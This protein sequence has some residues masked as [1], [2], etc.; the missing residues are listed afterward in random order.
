MGMI[1]V[2]RLSKTY[3]NFDSPWRRMYEWMF[4]IAH[5]ELK[6]TRL[7]LDDINFK[8]GSGEAVGIIGINGAGKSTLLKM[9]AGTAYPT[10]G[11]VKIT[12]SLASILELGLGFRPELTGRQNATTALQLLGNDFKRTQQL[13]DDVEEFAELGDYFELPLRVYSSGMQ[14]RL[15][16]S[17]VTA[18]RPDILV[19]DEALSVGDAYFQH[20]SF[21]RIRGF[22]ALGTTLLMV[23]HDKQAILAVCDRVILLND[24][25]IEREGD[26]E[27]VLDYYNAKLSHRRDTKISQEL[28][29]AGRVR[30][31]SGTKEVFIE[32]ISLLD[33]SDHEASMLKT[34]E[35][36]SIIVKYGSN[37]VVHDLVVGV[38]IKD[39]FGQAVFGTNSYHLKV[40]LP[41]MDPGN[42]GRVKFAFPVNLGEG[43]YSVSIALHKG[44]THVAH[45]FDWLDHAL[46]FE[47][48]NTSYT[49]FIGSTFLP[50]SLDVICE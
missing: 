6:S 13:L 31:S 17:A 16:F 23:S 9:I 45:N 4:P 28:N 25:R 43:H 48:V 33:D 20:K 46:V 50:M 19:V 32:S 40:S 15:A 41:S 14:M 49:H 12:G 30:T 35:G 42:V 24:G 39:R 11:F 29:P 47:V 34:G 44:P 37:Q 3:K 21:A 8:V 5:T 36:A 2:N 22:S 26:P 7:V 10:A 27:T 1:E 38:L 18:Q